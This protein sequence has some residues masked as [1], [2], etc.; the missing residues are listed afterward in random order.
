MSPR[1]ISE[2]IFENFLFRG[3]LPKKT[4]KL[5]GLTGPL[6]TLHR[7]SLHVIIVK[8]SFR[9]RGLVNFFYDVRFDATWRQSSPIFAFLPIFRHETLKRISGDSLQPRGHTLHDC[10][11]LT[12]IYRSSGRSKWVHFAS[13]VFLRLLVGELGTRKFAQISPINTH[14]VATLR[15]RSEPK[16]A[17]NA[18]LRARMCLLECKQCFP[19]LW[20]STPP[21]KK[22]L[23][24]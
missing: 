20:E 3:R 6:D 19:K 9:L 4:S 23:E 8:G 14:N 1:N 7:G 24:F 11:V 15:V 13:E 12:V 10:T 2:G 21:P 18:S 5:K 17:H 16:M 22:K